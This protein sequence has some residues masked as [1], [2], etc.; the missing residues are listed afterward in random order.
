MAQNNC[1]CGD[2][3]DYSLVTAI[4]GIAQTLVG[5]GNLDGLTGTYYTLFTANAN[6]GIIKSVRIKAAVAQVTKGMLRFFV[7]DGTNSSLIKEIPVVVTPSKQTTQIPPIVWPTYEFTMLTDLRLQAGDSLLVSTQNSESFNVF[8]EGL[9]WHY[10]TLHQTNPP[11]LTTCCNFKQ[12]TASNGLGTVS[13]ANTNLDGSGSGVVTLFTAGRVASGAKGSFVKSITIK[14]LQSTNPGMV[15][16]FINNGSASFLYKE[17]SVPETIQ[18]GFEPAWKMQWDENLYLET[19]FTVLA[20]TQIGQSFAL[21][22]E[23]Y[24]WTYPIS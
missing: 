15:R 10:P 19:N 7:T 16:L 6:G 5:N 8:V 2:G 20:T 11:D 18:S 21:T 13:T 4:T 23:A 17:I 12:E 3:K 24:D 22:I 14:A 9:N 1:G